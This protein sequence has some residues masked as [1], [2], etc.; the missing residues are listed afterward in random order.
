[1]LRCPRCGRRRHG[2]DRGGGRRRWRHQD[3][4]CFRA[5]LVLA[6]TAPGAAWSWRW[7]RGRSPA[8]DSPGI[9]SGSARG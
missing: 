1:M 7:R 5:E 4:G 8:A 2:Y 9:S 6:W 3:F